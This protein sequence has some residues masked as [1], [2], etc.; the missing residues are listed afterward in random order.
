VLSK[1]GVC[2]RSQAE[3]AVREGRVSVDGRLVRDPERATDPA[4]EQIQMDGQ[5]V[6]AAKRVYIALNKPR[7]IVVSAADERGR[8]TVYGLLADSNLPWLG[9][10]GRLDKASEGLLLLSN[11]SVWAARLTEPRHHVNKTYHVQIDA[12]PD[13]AVL[14][15]ILHG[16]ADKGERLAAKRVSLLRTGEKNAWLE[17]VLDEGRN[18]HIRRLLEVQGI[19][20]LRLI[21]VA[22]GDLALAELGKGQWRHLSEDE[23]MRLAG[24]HDDAATAKSVRA[25]APSAKSAPPRDGSARGPA[26]RK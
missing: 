16:I 6:A 5:T 10:V 19:G 3:K 22:I 1:L 18:R 12:I 13:Q 2:S 11:D 24:T 25:G 7:G 15:R 4:H 23:V 20:V 26:R 9:P 8:D 17:V 21:R 14:D